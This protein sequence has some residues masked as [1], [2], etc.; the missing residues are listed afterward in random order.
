MDSPEALQTDGW[1]PDVVLERYQSWLNAGETFVSALAANSSGVGCYSIA[2]L[3]APSFGGRLPIRICL[4]ALGTRRGQLRGS[5]LPNTSQIGNNSFPPTAVSSWQS[6]G[7]HG[8][9]HC[10]RSANEWHS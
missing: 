4:S 3:S 10:G 1:G 7:R 2:R 9:T 6:G 8:P 5:W